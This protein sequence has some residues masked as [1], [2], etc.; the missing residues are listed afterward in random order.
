MWCGLFIC[1]LA[2]ASKLLPVE[3]S[4]TNPFQHACTHTY[5]LHAYNASDLTSEMQYPKK[6]CPQDYKN[7]AETG[8]PHHEISLKFHV[9][10]SVSFQLSQILHLIEYVSVLT[11]ILCLKELREQN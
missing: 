11:Q 6:A 3:S 10:R 4:L 5:R 1:L 8:L 9:L 7:L 2:F